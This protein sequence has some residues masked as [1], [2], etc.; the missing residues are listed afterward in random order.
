MKSIRT[1]N[2]RWSQLLKTQLCKPLAHMYAFFKRLALYYAGAE[3]ACKSV[4][5]VELALSRNI[6]CGRLTQRRL[7]QR[8]SSCR[9]DVPEPPGPPQRRHP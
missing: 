8:F 4:T 1:C 7:C 9:L 5:M 2:V 6:S 3:T